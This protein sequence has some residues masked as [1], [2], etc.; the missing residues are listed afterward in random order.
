MN[1][2]SEGG[3]VNGRDRI[4]EVLRGREDAVSED[5]LWNLLGLARRWE[6]VRP[7][8]D[9]LDEL[10]HEGVVGR[11]YWFED[12]FPEQPGLQVGRVY[13]VWLRTPE[14]AERDRNIL[15]RDLTWAV[16]T[17]G[18]LSRDPEVLRYAAL[19]EP[20]LL[21]EVQSELLTSLPETTAGSDSP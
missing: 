8:S 2:S 7:F 3:G 11:S 12:E 16:F 5:D 19:R 14:T 4:I 10:V 20:E 6:I 15:R 1:G 13:R 9:T 17:G 18:R 21:G